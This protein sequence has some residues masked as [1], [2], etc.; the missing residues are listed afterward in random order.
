[1]GAKPKEIQWVSPYWLLLLVC[2]YIE[3]IHESW[4]Y[5]S[6]VVDLLRVGSCVDIY[7]E[8]VCLPLT[9]VVWQVEPNF[10][11]VP[12]PG[13]RHVQVGNFGQVLL[14][15]VFRQGVVGHQG[16]NLLIGERPVQ[17][18][19]GHMWALARHCVVAVS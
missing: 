19:L 12:S 5:V 1:M 17:V 9:K 15:Q 18:V 7:Q 4:Y 10:G 8:W 13:N 6:P 14:K 3:I 11:R 16:A 2:W